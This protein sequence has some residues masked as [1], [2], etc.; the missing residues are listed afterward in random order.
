MVSKEQSIK[1][2]LQKFPGFQNAWQEHLDWW[3]K[4][5]PGFCNDM[6]A[7][8]RYTIMLLKEKKNE[9]QLKEIFA[10]IEELMNVG[11]IEVKEAVATCFL[12]NFINA[13]AWGRI[14]ASSFVYLL[15]EE[16][17]KYCKA[18]DEFTGVKTEGLWDRE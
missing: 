5:T 11:T 15:G 12:E 16:S 1:L 14:P 6:A 8:S 9:Q 10:F 7:F 18:W 2:I 4:E 17:K 3:G 13:V